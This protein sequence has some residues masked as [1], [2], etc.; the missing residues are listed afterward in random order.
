MLDNGN[1]SINNLLHPRPQPRGIFCC[2]L[3]ANLQVAV[4]AVRHGNID[5]NR[6]RREEVADG[7]TQYKEQSARVG[8]MTC[9][10]CQ[11]EILHLL[12][13][14]QAI[15]HG[16][17]LV[18]HLHPYGPVFHLHSCVGIGLLKRRR[19]GNLYN[20]PVVL[21]VECYFL[22]HDFFTS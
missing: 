5:D 8:A 6:P 14:I 4:I 3:T 20:P 13:P 10:G 12:W 1:V 21:T 9:G 22:F 7:F 2:H 11:V 17:F 18:V 19:K 16:L 15:V